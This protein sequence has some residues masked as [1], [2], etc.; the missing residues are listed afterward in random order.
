MYGKAKAYALALFQLKH[1]LP[2]TIYV[3]SQPV[4]DENKLFAGLLGQEALR[5][6]PCCLFLKDSI[7]WLILF[8][9]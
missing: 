2:V 8:V 7:S 6:I 9:L 1:S 4:G 5:P 3:P